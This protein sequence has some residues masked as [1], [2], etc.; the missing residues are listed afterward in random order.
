MPRGEIV[1]VAFIFALIYTAG[2]LPKLAARLAG[3]DPKK[4][5]KEEEPK[6]QG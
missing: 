4:K 6:E 1:L 5:E 3:E 2:L